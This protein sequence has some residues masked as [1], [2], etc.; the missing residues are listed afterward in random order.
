MPV[1]RLPASVC[2]ISSTN[3]GLRPHAEIYH[4]SFAEREQPE[5][6]GLSGLILFLLSLLGK[7]S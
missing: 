1:S 6:G 2:A 3:A 7:G 5:Y 4:D